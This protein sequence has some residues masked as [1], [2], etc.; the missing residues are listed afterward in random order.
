MTPV[1]WYFVLAVFCLVALSIL[2]PLLREA[3]QRDREY[4][5]ELVAL[6]KAKP[7][8]FALEDERRRAKEWRAGFDAAIADVNRRFDALVA[9]LP[10][11]ADDPFDP[12]YWP[13]PAL[14][15]GP[16]LPVVSLARL[17]EFDP[18]ATVEIIR[19]R[20]RAHPVFSWTTGSLPVVVPTERPERLTVGSWRRVREH[21][22]IRI[23]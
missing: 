15:D 12:A 16:T 20:N 6:E 8:D 7:V 1:G 21:S 23:T 2:V 10:T 18:A 14:D 9:D 4:A 5:A 22:P 11:T 19:E 13:A 17:A 3:R